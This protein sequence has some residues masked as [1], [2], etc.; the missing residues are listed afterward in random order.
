MAFVS[1]KIGT[2]T[3]RIHSHMLCA[4]VNFGIVCYPKENI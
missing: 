4:V 2:F 3:L 1:I